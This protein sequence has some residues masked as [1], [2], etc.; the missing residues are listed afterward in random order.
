[1]TFDKDYF[2][3]I[4]DFL[5]KPENLDRTFYLANLTADYDKFVFHVKYY[6]ESV[7]SGPII[8]LIEIV[9]VKCHFL[10]PPVLI[11]DLGPL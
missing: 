6:I 8:D 1:M 10:K 9:F 2:N 7:K 11:P 3:Q 4:Y 5:N